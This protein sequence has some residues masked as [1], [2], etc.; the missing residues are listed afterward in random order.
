[1]AVPTVASTIP[2]SIS[3]AAQINPRQERLLCRRASCRA[4]RVQSVQRHG[5]RSGA[6]SG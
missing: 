5:L 2:A 3:T 4:S 1:M 6:T